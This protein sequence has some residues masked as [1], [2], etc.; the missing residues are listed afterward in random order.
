[1]QRSK[2]RSS[3]LGMV[4]AVNPFMNSQN[5]WFHTKYLHNENSRIDR[6]GIIRLDTSC[7]VTGC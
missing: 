5:T 1:M 3:E 7:E 4:T 2:M 6:E